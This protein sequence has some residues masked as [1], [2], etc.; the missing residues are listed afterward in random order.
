[1]TEPKTPG[2]KAGVVHV[3]SP[4]GWTGGQCFVHH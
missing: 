4:W 2:D 3:A 1:M